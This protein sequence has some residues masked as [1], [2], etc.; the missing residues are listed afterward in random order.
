MDVRLWRQFDPILLATC[1]LLII[2]GTAMIYAAAVTP[3][4]TLTALSILGRQLGVAAIGLVFLVVAATIDYRIYRTFFWPLVIAN[5]GLLAV[6]LAIGRE[7]HGAQRWINAGFFDVQPSELGK[8]LLILTL[9]KF[10]ADH[11]EQMGQVR[12]FL[13]SLAL[14]VAPALLVYPQPDLGTAI[15]YVAIWFGMVF[16]A[17]AR[18]RHLLL[19]SCVALAS[20][21]L[22][23]RFARGYMLQRLAIFLDPQSDPSGAGYNIIQALISI[24]SGGWLGQGYANGTQT[25]LSFLRVRYTDFIFSVI[26]EELGFVGCI[27]LFVLFLTLLVR[28]LRVA[29]F[30]RDGYGRM[31]VVGIVWMFFFQVLVNVSMNMQLMPVTGIPLPFISYGRSS[32]LTGMF[33]IGILE[34]VLMRHRRIT[35]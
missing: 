20:L 2:Y 8:L 1:F 19:L 14:A 25:Q 23:L 4:D 3:D 7:S 28:S 34:S 21:P 27:L 11:E 35:F 18:W 33:A 10:L 31:L 17:G 12:Y 6:V 30:A 16:D 32:L 22:A 15:V 24:G 13:G 29:S 26:G 5:L 9:G